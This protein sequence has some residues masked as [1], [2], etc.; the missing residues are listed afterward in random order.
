[1]TAAHSGNSMYLNRSVAIIKPKKP[2]IDWVNSMPV[3]DLPIEEEFFSEDALA[4]LIPEYDTLEEARE[5]IGNI[6]KDIFF[7]ELWGW[8]TDEA[9]WPKRRTLKMFWQWFD[10]EFHSEVVDSCDE[11]I[12]EEEE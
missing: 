6:W 11:P 1:M 2:F 3:P 8:C 7:N 5:H 9:Q 12:R 4:V 10:V